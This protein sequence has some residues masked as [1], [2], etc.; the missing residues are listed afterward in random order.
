MACEAI[1]FAFLTAMHYLCPR[2]KN[3][4]VME[5]QCPQCG[6]WMAVSQ[7]ELVIHGSQVVCPQCLAVCSYE[8][9]KL[10]VH[11]DS[12][13]PYRH[14][15]N[16]DASRRDISK[17]CHSCGKKL[18]SGIRFCPYC[19]TDIQAPFEQP[20]PRVEQQQT[21]VQEPVTKKK[22]EPEKP[23]PKPKTTTQSSSS[24]VE[25]KLRSMPHRYSSDMQ[26]R[27]H[28]R[29]TMPSRTF[30]LVAYSIIVILLIILAWIIVA[31]LNIETSV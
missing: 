2:F 22:P 21:V 1:F 24:V 9:D 5:L 14:T 28:Q 25:N 20:K 13:A 3:Y 6:K 10:V 31:G 23:Q 8:G 30:K 29:G 27:I 17:F 7:E 26:P 19:G 12:D 16:A 15:A 18:P 4:R 11:D